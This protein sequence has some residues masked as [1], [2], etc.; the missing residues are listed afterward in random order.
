MKKLIYLKKN[1]IRSSKLNQIS[2]PKKTVPLGKI[3]DTTINKDVI[4][5]LDTDMLSRKCNSYKISLKSSNYR[6]ISKSLLLID[7]EKL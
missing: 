3:Y 7:Y 6:V 5:K 1:K 4:F 2:T